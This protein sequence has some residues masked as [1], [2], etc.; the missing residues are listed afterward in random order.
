[1][2]NTF[3]DSERVALEVMGME[4]VFAVL[5]VRQHNPLRIILFFGYHGF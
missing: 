1:M 4:I 5:P 2:M 3:S